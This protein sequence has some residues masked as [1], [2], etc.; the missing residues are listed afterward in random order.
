MN[1][2]MQSY[3]DTNVQ[4]IARE[5]PGTKAESNPRVCFLT[6]ADF[7]SL[8]YDPDT[9]L[10][11]DITENFINDV[12]RKDFNKIINVLRRYR[13]AENRGGVKDAK[14]S[15]DTALRYLYSAL[16]ALKK[17]NEDKLVRS[18]IECRGFLETAYYHLE[19]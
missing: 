8:L 7:I 16:S 2:R 19:N 17:R 9:N 5:L 14:K 12:M 10:A 11:T 18:L 3:F 13:G 6:L 15:M 1:P 4:K